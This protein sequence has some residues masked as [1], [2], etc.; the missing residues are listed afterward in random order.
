MTWHWPSIFT[1]NCPTLEKKKMC[2]E[3]IDKNKKKIKK[4]KN[5]FVA[6]NSITR[7]EIIPP[8]VL[9]QVNTSR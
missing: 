8:L 4:N 7:V 3:A 5:T 2:E 9:Y 1:L 6:I